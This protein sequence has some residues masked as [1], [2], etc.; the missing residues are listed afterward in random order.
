MIEIMQHNSVLKKELLDLLDVR[1]D[2]IYVDATYGRGGHCGIVLEKISE[3]GKVIAFDRDVEAVAHAISEFGHDNR[4]TINHAKFSSLSN[5]LPEYRSKI[6]GIYFDLG[7]STPQL[8]NA[9]RGFSFRN[10]GI[11]DMRMD[12]S[13]DEL[14]A[15]DW[16]NGA[17]ED[18]IREVLINFGEER[19]AKLIAKKI[20]DFRK[21]KM[22]ETTHELAQIIRSCIRYRKKNDPATLTFQAV[23]IFINDELNELR[24]A[25]DFAAELLTIGGKLLVISF[26]SLEDRIVKHR[27][28]YFSRN[29][30]SFDGSNYSYQIVTKKPIRPSEAEKFENVRSR[31]AKLR[32]I[33][34][35]Q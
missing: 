12:Q 18:E 31:S 10:S 11:L 22:I 25:L 26:H 17:E 19:N 8:D 35:I 21:V 20:M 1:E 5:L 4:F 7:L 16:L 29:G 32:V 9:A 3:F 28:R 34:R 2:G 13:S 27:F 24:E 14:S 30:L 33:K 23:R 15:S 6:N